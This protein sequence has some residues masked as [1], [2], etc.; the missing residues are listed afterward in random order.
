MS[1]PLGPV[2]SRVFVVWPCPGHTSTKSLVT[3]ARASDEAMQ[4]WH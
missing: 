2:V 3:C 1:Y 4:R